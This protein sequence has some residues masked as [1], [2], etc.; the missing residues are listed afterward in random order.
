MGIIHTVLNPVFSPF[1]HLGTIFA[2]I[3]LA[4]VINLI[5]SGMQMVFVDVKKMRSLQKE[6]KDHRKKIMAAA[7]AGE[8]DKDPEAASSQ[9]RMME[10]QQELMKL[11]TPMF[12]SMIPIIFVF[13]WMREAFIG[14]GIVINLPHSL[15]IWGDSLGW[16]GW[17]ILA[18]FPTSMLLR[19][20]VRIS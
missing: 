12:L 9:S 10:I 1:L 13:I 8:K 19:K 17:Y 7:K 6:M 3:A 2:I 16:L 14:T 20:L 18:S 11:Q 5:S 4:I 15:P